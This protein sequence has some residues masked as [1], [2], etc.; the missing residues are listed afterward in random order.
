M[1]KPVIHEFLNI[2]TALAVY[3]NWEADMLRLMPEAVV[4]LGTLTT[5]GGATLYALSTPMNS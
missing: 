4:S 1:N 2:E 3:Q 5:E